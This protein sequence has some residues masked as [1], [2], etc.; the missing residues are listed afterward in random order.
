ML[1]LAQP[2]TPPLVG[3]RLASQP[4]I[5]LADCLGPGELIELSGKYVCA[6]TSTAVSFL[7]A[8]QARGEPTAWVQP[9]NG[10]LYPPDLANA[11]VDLNALVV[12]HI[13]TAAKTLGL[14]KAAE[15]L[16]RSGAF[17][18]VV[19]DLLEGSLRGDPSLWQGRLH[20]LVRKHQST[21]CLLT[22]SDARTSS[23]GSLISLRLH[24]KRFCDGNGEW[25][26][27]HR[28]LKTKRG[29]HTKIASSRATP[30]L[31]LEG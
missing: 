15:Y 22:D 8:V 6:R 5:T 17:G 31:G 12:V 16:L 21:L 25:S 10:T 13:P 23:L 19:V 18:L 27:H 14:I 30:P 28:I 4:P 11:G 29:F 24:S 7:R 2:T 1:K 26:I 20:G 9:E 3:E